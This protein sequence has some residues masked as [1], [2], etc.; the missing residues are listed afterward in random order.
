MAEQSEGGRP[1]GWAVSSPPGWRAMGKETGGGVWIEPV[2]AWAIYDNGYGYPV[3]PNR[4]DGLVEIME[5]GVELLA[6]DEPDPPKED[7]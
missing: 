3:V 4:G 5:S 1:A 6:P 7:G 2:I